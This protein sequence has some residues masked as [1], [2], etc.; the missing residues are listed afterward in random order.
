VY[1]VPYG[2]L[3]QL[4]EEVNQYAADVVVLEPADLRAAVIRGLTAVA[5]QGQAA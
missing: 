4:A 3:W 5:A 2:D 1:A